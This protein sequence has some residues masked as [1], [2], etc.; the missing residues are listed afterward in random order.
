MCLCWE[1]GALPAKLF[2][3]LI[4]CIF[5]FIYSM[6]LICRNTGWGSN[7]A[8]NQL[9]TLRMVCILVFLNYYYFR[10]CAFNNEYGN[11]FLLPFLV[12]YLW[13]TYESWPST[14]TLT[15]STHQEETIEER[16]L[17]YSPSLLIYYEEKQLHSGR[18]KAWAFGVW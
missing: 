6:P 3:I 11:S 16:F 9:I 18:Q 17:S 4:I 14:M 7:P 10:V 13:C 2:E 1:E 15:V 5:Y 12:L 8:R